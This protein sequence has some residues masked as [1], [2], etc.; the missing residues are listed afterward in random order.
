MKVVVRD[1]VGE[2][3]ITLDDGQKIY[4]LIHPELVAGNEVELEFEGV[5][6]FA[7]PFFNAAIGQL[8]K[9]IEAA[10]LNRL[11]KI[12]HITPVGKMVLRRVI[13]NAKEYYAATEAIREV[14][15]SIVS[16]NIEES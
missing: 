16:K 14:V 7:S 3:G 11:L 13:Q 8:L 15:N 5:T 4:D 1:I 9:D 6:I 12:S 2:Y 10:D